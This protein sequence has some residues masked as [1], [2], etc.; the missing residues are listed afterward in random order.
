MGMLYF[1]M[2]FYIKLVFVTRWGIYKIQQNQNN[3]VRI[4]RPC[5]IC[6]CRLIL[7]KKPRYTTLGPSHQI[8]RIYYPSFSPQHLFF[9]ALF[10]PLVGLISPLR[11][12]CLAMS[13]SNICTIIEYPLFGSYIFVMTTVVMTSVHTST[14]YSPQTQ[15]YIFDRDLLEA[16]SQSS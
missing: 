2:K 7:C 5:F 1:E 15:I 10:T 6:P 8:I 11:I 14:I 16:Y 4:R 13:P 12:Y 3:K 9:F